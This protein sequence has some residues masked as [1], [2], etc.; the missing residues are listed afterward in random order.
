MKRKN[1]HKK[2][3]F[4]SN[5]RSTSLLN[6]FVRIVMVLVVLGCC[7][8]VLLLFTTNEKVN[9][10]KSLLRRTYF[11][12]LIH[13]H[14]SSNKIDIHTTYMY[15]CSSPPYLVIRIL[16]HTLTQAIMHTYVTL[17]P[18]DSRS[19]HVHSTRIL[20]YVAETSCT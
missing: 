1:T 8:Y 17:E 20:R 4:F 9:E 10:R 16:L 12:I 6:L 3:R 13:T 7:Y 19:L 11:S 5:P 14:I 18:Q 15:K 2:R